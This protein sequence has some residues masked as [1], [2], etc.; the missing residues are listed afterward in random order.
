ML[1]G[2]KADLELGLSAS[3]AAWTLAPLPVSSLVHLRSCLRQCSHAIDHSP[4]QTK[5][6][7]LVLPELMLMGGVEAETRYL[8]AR[9][10][11]LGNFQA[12]AVGQSFEFR[13]R[14][15]AASVRSERYLGLSSVHGSV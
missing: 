12:Q 3:I 13:V 8:S 14:A 15:S 4:A 2:E 5:T 7:F 11:L 1:V 10:V 6:Y 9:R